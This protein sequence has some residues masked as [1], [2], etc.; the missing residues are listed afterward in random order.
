MLIPQELLGLLQKLSFYSA[1]FSNSHCRTPALS[2]DI[3]PQHFLSQAAAVYEA[4]R[5]C[6]WDMRGRYH[7]RIC[8]FTPGALLLV[9]AQ[10]DYYDISDNNI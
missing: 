5:R 3:R 7:I 2:D 4:F 9:W 10:P 6:A 1:I 8:A